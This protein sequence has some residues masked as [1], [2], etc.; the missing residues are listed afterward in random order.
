MKKVVFFLI[1]FTFTS[2]KLFF[3]APS[4]CELK[5]NLVSEL[6]TFLDINM[7]K[8]TLDEVRTKYSDF[9]QYDKSWNM[10]IYR[11]GDS[12][13]SYLILFYLIA[14]SK[15]DQHFEIVSKSK[16]GT[17]EN[18]IINQITIWDSKFFRLTS[19]KYFVINEYC[20][21]IQTL[22]GLRIGVTKEWVKKVFGL[23]TKQNND[24][25]KYSCEARGVYYSIS[26]Q[27]E[28]NKVI[29]FMLQQFDEKLLQA[30]LKK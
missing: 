2:N 27:F 13:Y 18:K 5:I 16:G 28:E 15:C 11:S 25:W 22:H 1:F 6:Q 24:Y 4:E 3:A 10:D 8:T 26:M 17:K 21:K 7:N 19:K 20:N 9:E 23:P 12:I 14:D 30:E 29:K